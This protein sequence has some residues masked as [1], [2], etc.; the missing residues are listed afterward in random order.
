MMNKHVLFQVF[1]NLLLRICE[2]LAHGSVFER[3]KLF[4]RLSDTIS[5]MD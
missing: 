3:L 2:Q 5:L 1:A 4:A